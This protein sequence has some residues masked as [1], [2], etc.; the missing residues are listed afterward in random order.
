MVEDGLW[1]IF[2]LK[3][4]ALVPTMA[5]TKAGFYIGIEPVE[6]VDAHDQAAFEQAIIRVVRRGNP[7]VPTPPGG[8]QFPKSV[9]LKYAKLNSIS[10]FDKIAKSWQLSKREGAYLIIP[11]RPRKDSGAEE[12]TVRGEAIPAEEPL[13]TVVRRLVRR[14]L[15]V[16]DGTGGAPLKD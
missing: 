6:V 7:S 2:R 4:Q 15:D 10:A 3:E 12:N 14:V 8:A 1:L 9:L 16:G 5:K 13:E 11:Y